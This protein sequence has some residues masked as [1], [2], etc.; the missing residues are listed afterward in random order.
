MITFTNS[1]LLAIIENSPGIYFDDICVALGFERPEPE[2]AKLEKDV[3]TRPVS[4]ALQ[5]LFTN[6]M[7]HPVNV[8]EQR[9]RGNWNPGPMPE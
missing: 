9:C 4:L 2:P 6:K 8:G 5:N 3:P 1:Q 7:I